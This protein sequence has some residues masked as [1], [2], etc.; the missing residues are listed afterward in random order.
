MEN[1]K[2]NWHIAAIAGSILA[3]G[4]GALT[5]YFMT[6]PKDHGKHHHDFNYK[7]AGKNWTSICKI[8][9]SHSDPNLGKCSKS[10]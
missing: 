6:K 10:Y 2:K 7:D 3:I 8:V 9:F 5:Y 4:A 1:L